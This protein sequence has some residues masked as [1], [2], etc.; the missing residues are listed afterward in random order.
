[1]TSIIRFYSLLCLLLLVSTTQYA[2]ASGAAGD[3]LRS[4]LL[5]RDT[6]RSTSGEAFGQSAGTTAP[7]DYPFSAAQD[8][9]FH[10]W[11]ALPLSAQTRFRLDVRRVF[12]EAFSLPAAKLTANEI[13]RQNVNVQSLISPLE[14]PEIRDYK[15]HLSHSF[16]IPGI[17][18]FGVLPGLFGK[19]NL[20]FITDSFHEDVTPVLRYTLDAPAFVNVSVFSQQAARVRLLFQGHEEIGSYS[21]VWNGRNDDG[22]KV[23]TGDYVGIV[24]IGTKTALRKRIRVDE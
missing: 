24:S 3:S 17:K 10:E 12:D 9:R 6:T 7:G 23:A 14:M 8:R 22:F 13:A 19:G 21:R 4:S 1:M 16:S 15:E 5:L 2:F 20:G 11:L 18:T